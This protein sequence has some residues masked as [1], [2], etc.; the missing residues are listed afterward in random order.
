MNRKLTFF[1]FLLAPVLLH[2]RPADACGGCFQP[3]PPRVGTDRPQVV[4][5]HR[6]VLSIASTQTTLWDQIRYSGDPTQ[7]IWVLPIRSAQDVQ[8][9]L[10]DNAFIDAVDR[11]S[12]PIIQGVGLCPGASRPTTSG[13]CAP[14]LS[15]NPTQDMTGTQGASLNGLG[16]RDVGPYS[17]QIVSSR[18]IP[19]ADW[20]PREGLM[21]PA[22]TRSAVEYYD[23]LS[24]DYIVLRMRP[25]QGVQQ[26]QPVR[27][28]YPGAAMALPLRMI[29]AGAGDSVALS[30]FIFAAGRVTTSN[31]ASQ[32][33]ATEQIQFDFG[34]GRSNYA[35]LAN[36]VLNSRTPTW[37]L[38]NSSPLVSG[39]MQYRP[40]V[41]RATQSGRFA[42]GQMMM[43]PPPDPIPDGGVP[44]PDM[45]GPDVPDRDASE[46]PDVPA[47]SEDVIL[48]ESDAVDDGPATPTPTQVDVVDPADATDPTDA[49]EPT[50]VPQTPQQMLPV[51][52]YADL[53]YALDPLGA[54]IT[55][56]RLRARLT[57]VALDR[58]LT[59]Q[60]SAEPSIPVLR[61]TTN[62]TN[63]ACPSGTPGGSAGG[64]ASPPLRYGCGCSVPTLT[65]TQWV[66]PASLLAILTVL[67]ARR[68][69]RRAKRKETQNS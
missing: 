58:D 63:L 7:F 23:R 27:V 69:Q 13:G 17:A 22:E 20:L 47:D 3:P 61:S 8:I 14:G 35:T 44:D 2:E 15:F 4:T 6:M 36:T 42:A 29:V 53:H 31:F 18:M 56:T 19:L 10:G 1:A 67:T 54:S 32:S 16:A 59:L 49:A 30:L 51:D 62:V 50:D 52:P 9:G 26:I 55:L 39:L 12:A 68:M 66:S 5:D 21:V 11:A 37:L 24:F 46:N 43:M 33:I 57:A 64:P 34:T 28:T 48:V 60:S 45:H 40:S 38:E 65:A 25:G 41:N